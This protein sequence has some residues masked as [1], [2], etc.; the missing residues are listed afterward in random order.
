MGSAEDV[1]KAEVYRI[2]VSLK[3]G[4]WMYCTPRHA[5]QKVPD[6]ADGATSAAC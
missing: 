2:T 5:P 3:D 6:G 1:S 4:L